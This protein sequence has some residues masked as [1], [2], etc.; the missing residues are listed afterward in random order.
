MFSKQNLNKQYFVLCL[1][2]KCNAAA[3][4]YSWRKVKSVEWVEW[5]EYGLQ[6]ICSLEFI[7][8]YVYCVHLQEIQGRKSSFLQF[9]L[10]FSL[11]KY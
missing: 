11:I 1:R 5:S 3:A 10:G 9:L 8:T 7:C 4:E 6:S 2:W